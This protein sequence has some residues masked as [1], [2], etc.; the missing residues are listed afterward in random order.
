V[1]SYELVRDK[2]ILVIM[3]EGPLRSEDFEALGQAVDDY[4][5]SDGA[6]TGIMISA[7][8]FPG[9]ED[10]GGFLSHMRF[11]K[12]NNRDVDKV[13]AV[14][15]SAF[16]S[17]MPRV[18]ALFISAEVRHFAIAERD[19]AMVWLKSGLAKS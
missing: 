6:L 9:W 17:I 13:A 14:T 19:A 12:E 10:F 2:G 15:D 1:L 3:P 5:V 11:V 8:R 18:V 4:V 7:E 16:L